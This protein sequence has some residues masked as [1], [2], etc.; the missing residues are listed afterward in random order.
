VLVVSESIPRG[1]GLAILGQSPQCKLGVVLP[2]RREHSECLAGGKPAG[3]S[4]STG[5]DLDPFDD[6]VGSGERFEVVEIIN[7]VSELF[8]QAQRRDDL[9]PA[10]G[11]SL[12]DKRP[13]T[14][15]GSVTKGSFKI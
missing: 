6:R 12:A 13:L 10:R 3:L 1:F 7:L 2:E 9:V 5:L 4:P 11:P 8:F 15:V 14:H